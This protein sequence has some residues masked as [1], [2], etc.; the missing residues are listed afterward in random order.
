MPKCQLC[1]EEEEKLYK[2]VKCGRMFCEWC[3]S[4][5]DLICVECSDEDDD[6]DDDWDYDE[7]EDDP[8]E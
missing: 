7:D 8:E 2:C 6:D 1:D 3:G 4:T 5:E